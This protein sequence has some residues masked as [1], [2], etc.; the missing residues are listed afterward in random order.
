MPGLKGMD[1][2]WI[3]EWVR[4]RA[5]RQASGGN[6]RGPC[7]QKDSKPEPRERRRRGMNQKTST[8]AGLTY[9]SGWLP[10]VETGVAG[11]SRRRK[12]RTRKLCC[13]RETAR[14]RCKFRSTPSIQAVVVSF[15]TVSCSNWHGRAKF[16]EN[17][18]QKTLNLAYRSFKVIHFG[19]N[20]CLVYGFI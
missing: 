20:R 14:C 7:G 10:A 12:Y 18:P 19:T 5:G 1:N 16:H 2:R 13:H 3:R 8:D 4:N 6:W 17:L 11:A 15:D 9:C